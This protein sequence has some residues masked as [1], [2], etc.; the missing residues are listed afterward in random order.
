MAAWAGQFPGREVVLRVKCNNKIKTRKKSLM[1]IGRRK[2]WYLP[3]GR[4]KRL[5]FLKIE[6]KTKSVQS[7]GEE[8]R[9]RNHRPKRN[10]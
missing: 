4:V 10:N 2:G 8:M 7:R 3:R 9:M 6:A 1:T 5:L